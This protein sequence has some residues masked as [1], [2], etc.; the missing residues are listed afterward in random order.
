MRK[1]EIESDIKCKAEQSKDI[2]HFLPRDLLDGCKEQQN[3]QERSI[4]DAFYECVCT[5]VGGGIV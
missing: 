2:K 5:D 3:Q 4:R 1:R